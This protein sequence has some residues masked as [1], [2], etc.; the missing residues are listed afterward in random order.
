[1]SVDMAWL[2]ENIF[3]KELP[4]SK[5]QA[6]ACLKEVTFASGEKII[7]EGQAGGTLEIMR[8]G[9]A[10]VEDNNRYEGRVTLTEIEP[11]TVFG[12]LAFL[13]NRSRTADVTAM[14]ECVVYSLSQDDFTQLM[15]HHHELAYAILI[16]IL[17]RQTSVIMS[18]RITIAPILRRL[19]DKTNKLPLIVKL[20]PIIFTLIYFG[21]LAF[22]SLRD[23]SY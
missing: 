21:G 13:S 8:S 23:L 18:Q 10:K 7:E 15:K 22:V 12:E 9:R 5:R 3:K 4:D 1:M 19:N 11:G 16:T 6:L 14:E 20:V 2:E 17:E